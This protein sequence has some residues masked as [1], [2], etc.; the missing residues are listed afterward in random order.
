[1]EQVAALPRVKSVGHR[2]YAIMLLLLVLVTINYIDRANLAVA[3]PQMAKEFGWS[4]SVL[5][6]AFSAL[7]WGLYA[8]S[9]GV[10]RTHRCG[11]YAGCLCGRAVHM[12]GGLG[13]DWPR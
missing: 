6:V 3:G 13:R 9:A 7:F 1:M 2:R 4:L 8:V 5:G 11:G 10:G 12:V